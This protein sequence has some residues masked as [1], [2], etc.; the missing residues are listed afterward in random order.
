MNVEALSEALE[1]FS[2]Q[3]LSPLYM[4]WAM[5]FMDSQRE[6]V[7][8]GLEGRSYVLDHPRRV[9]ERI[10]EDFLQA[11]NASWLD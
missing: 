11:E 8:S 4:G 5:G 1:V 2:D 6:G 9:F 3:L 7:E 10:A